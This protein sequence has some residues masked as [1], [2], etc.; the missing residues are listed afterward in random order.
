[1]IE[2]IG[3]HGA[4][5]GQLC[6]NV[7]SILSGRLVEGNRKVVDMGKE[8]QTS[9]TQLQQVASAGS[10]KDQA[11]RQMQGKVANMQ[12][13]FKGS[14]VQKKEVICLPLQPAPLLFLAQRVW[15]PCLLPLKILK[16]KIQLLFLR[17]L[18]K[19]KENEEF[20]SA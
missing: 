18:K 3:E 13:A 17:K 20:F 12:N 19:L 2:F 11:L 8:L 16:L 5:G 4:A 15:W 10:Q 9:F 1:M 7:A 6:L 14:S